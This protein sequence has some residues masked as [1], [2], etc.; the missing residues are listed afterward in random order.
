MEHRTGM[1]T[2]D[3][4]QACKELAVVMEASL[5]G[6][7]T[8]KVEECLRIVAAFED[9]NFEDMEGAVREITEGLIN[10]ASG[11]QDAQ[12]ESAT[13]LASGFRLALLRVMS[14]NT[15]F[16]SQNSSELVSSLVV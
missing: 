3:G 6:V 12:P 7:H 13:S 8:P 15:R 9:S 2:S 16:G 10:A 5:S 4:K 11:R 1:A 14:S